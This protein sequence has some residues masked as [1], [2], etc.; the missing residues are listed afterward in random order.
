MNLPSIARLLGAVAAVLVVASVTTK[1]IADSTGQYRFLARLFYVDSEQNIPSLYS[2]MLLLISALLLSVIAVLKSKQRAPYAKY[3]ALLSVGFLLMAIDEAAS[4]H[5][6]F[7]R[8]VRNLL[9]GGDLGIFHFAWVVPGIILVLMLAV[10]FLKFLSHLPAKTRHSFLLAGTLFIGGSIGFELIGGHY[11]E[12][13]GTR[14]LFYSMLV[15]VEESLEMAG[16]IVFIWALL[17]YITDTYKDVQFRFDNSTDRS[18]SM[19]IMSGKVPHWTGIPLGPL[20]AGENG[21]LSTSWHKAG[22]VHY[23]IVRKVGR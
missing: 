22:D 5:E 11:A 7:I 13:H 10:F 3:W 4:I 8:P 2:T 14:D 16:V 21:H 1:L 9:G 17:V 20:H 18:Q 15:T 19:V 6:I 23:P 12:L